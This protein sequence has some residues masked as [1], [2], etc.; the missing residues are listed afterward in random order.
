MSQLNLAH[1]FWPFSPLYCLY[2]HSLCYQPIQQ[3]VNWMATC[4]K[5]W[6]SIPERGSFLLP[7]VS[8]LCPDQCR[9]WPS[10][11]F[12]ECGDSLLSRVGLAPRLCLMF[13]ICA[14]LC[15]RDV[16]HVH[17]D[18]FTSSLHPFRIYQP[19][20]YELYLFVLRARPSTLYFIILTV[21]F[22]PNTC[23]LVGW[24]WLRPFPVSK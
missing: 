17:T 16:A 4:L 13:C 7:P 15:L 14:C 21:L 3:S 10:V 12:S 23:L 18:Y 9:C 19:K 5:G 8:L 6:S 22:T 20:F 2:V 24:I 11:L 1:N